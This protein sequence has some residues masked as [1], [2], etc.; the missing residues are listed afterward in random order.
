[1][2]R[3]GKQFNVDTSGAG[4]ITN[5]YI[6]G[7]MMGTQGSSFHSQSES[8][9]SDSMMV[10]MMMLMM[11]DQDG[12]SEKMPLLLAMMAGD[13]DAIM[14]I[15]FMMQFFSEPKSSLPASTTTTLSSDM[16]TTSA[17]SIV[18]S[19]VHPHICRMCGEEKG[20]SISKVCKYNFSLFVF[21]MNLC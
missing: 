1:M 3:N 7:S 8:S 6:S 11:H 18:T 10:V 14:M 21:I 2:R 5:V 17:V 4:S 16:R 9:T 19:T 12:S 15:P 20:S 13:S